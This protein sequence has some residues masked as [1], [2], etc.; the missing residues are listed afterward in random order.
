MPK[1]K[2]KVE[3]SEAEIVVLKEITHNGK[4]NSAKTILHANVLLN[5]NDLSEKKKTDREISE[6]FGISKTTVNAIRTTYSEKGIE[7]ALSRKTRLDAPIL[8]KITGDFEAQVIAMSLGPAP[9]GRANWTLRLLAEQCMEKKYI[10][11]IS[12]TAIG[13]MLNTNEVK[14]HL[15]K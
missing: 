5:T 13:E 10:V 6:I 12:H 7:A 15:S 8:S 11:S 9:S 14:R 4:E 3:L 2:Y 1:E